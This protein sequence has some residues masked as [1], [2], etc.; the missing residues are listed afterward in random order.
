MSLT[1]SPAVLDP[2]NYSYRERE[3]RAPAIP[4][5]FTLVFDEPGRVLGNVCYRSHYLRVTKDEF[6]SFHQLHVQHGA[7]TE[8]WRFTYLKSVIDALASLDSDSRYLLL[9]TIMRANQE[10]A[11]RTAEKVAANW[12]KAA[13]QKRIK[14]RKVKGGVKVWVEPELI[15]PALTAPVNESLIDA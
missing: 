3:W 12:Q 7:G 10:S 4:E 9:H 15:A 13:A 6:G 11:T 5:S 2:E 8:S 1:Y 14:T